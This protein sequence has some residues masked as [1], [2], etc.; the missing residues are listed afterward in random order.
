MAA[1]GNFTRS[2]GFYRSFS[3]MKIGKGPILLSK[4]SPCTQE[5]RIAS[6]HQFPSPDIKNEKVARTFIVTLDEKSRRLLFQEMQNFERERT[7]TA[8]ENCQ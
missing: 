1:W 6:V 2:F 7:S 3:R 8:G 4:R 5:L